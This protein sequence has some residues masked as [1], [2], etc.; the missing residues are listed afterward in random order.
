LDGEA[1]HGAERIRSMRRRLT[2][3][4]ALA[5]SAAAAA[6]GIRTELADPGLPSCFSSCCINHVRN[7]SASPSVIAANA[8]WHRE[9]DQV[10]FDGVEMADGPGLQVGGFSRYDV[11]NASSVLLSRRAS[12][13]GPTLASF[14]VKPRLESADPLHCVII[15]RVSA[16]DRGVQCLDASL[17]SLTPFSGIGPSRMTLRFL[18][19]FHEQDPP[20]AVFVFEM[21]AIFL[22]FCFRFAGF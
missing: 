20:A 6:D 4:G 22:A 14:V 5:S 16:H 2:A 15:R 21:L 18:L 13:D 12:C 17:T 10:L 1:F 19:A 11:T 9:F 3:A 7:S 8:Y